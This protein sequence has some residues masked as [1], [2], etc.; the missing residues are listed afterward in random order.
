MTTAVRPLFITTAVSFSGLLFRTTLVD[1]TG[2]LRETLTQY[3][4]FIVLKFKHSQ[5]FFPGLAVY[6]YGLIVRRTPGKQLLETRR[7]RGQKPTRSLYSPNSVF[8]EVLG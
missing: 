8:D 4:T 1:Y 2:T 7:T 6:L 3:N 5:P